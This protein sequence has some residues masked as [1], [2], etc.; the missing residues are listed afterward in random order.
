M[1]FMLKELFLKNQMMID[2]DDHDDHNDD[3]DDH[4]DDHDDHNDYNYH[5]E[6]DDY[7]NEDH[8]HILQEERWKSCKLKWERQ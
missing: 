5:D 4:D 1:R 3:H 7:D 6:Y 8:I 2:H